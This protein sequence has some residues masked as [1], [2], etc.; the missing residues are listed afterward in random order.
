M[1]SF[2][3]FFLKKKPQFFSGGM[4]TV[5]EKNKTFGKRRRR[6]G[7]VVQR[8][9]SLSGLLEVMSWRLSSS[10]ISSSSPHWMAGC[11]PWHL[12]TFQNHLCN[13]MGEKVEEEMISFLSV[14]VREACQTELRAS[15]SLLLRT[16]SDPEFAPVS[17]LQIRSFGSG[18]HRPTGS[19]TTAVTLSPAL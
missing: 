1:L 6:E 16:P 7:D 17:W 19:E 11:D 3:P 15:Y 4:Q 18:F 5:Q 8:R 13:M 14:S 10:S 2:F 12:K 9:G